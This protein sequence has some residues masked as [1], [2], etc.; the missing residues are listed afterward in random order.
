MS[1]PIVLLLAAVWAIAI[2]ITGILLVAGIAREVATTCTA[3]RP[4]PRPRVGSLIGAS[5]G[6]LVLLSLAGAAG[7][8]VMRGL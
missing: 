2:A 3:G 5:L 6:A 4:A 8:F 7:A 1:N